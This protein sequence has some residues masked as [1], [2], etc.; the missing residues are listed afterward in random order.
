M[1]RS[2]QAIFTNLCMFYME[3]KIL[4]EFYYHLENGD[5]KHKLL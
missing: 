3:N 4:S 1:S 5:W 2:E